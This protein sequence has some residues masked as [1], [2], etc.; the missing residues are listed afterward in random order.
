LTYQELTLHEPRT[1][2]DR[3][4]NSLGMEHEIKASD[5]IEWLNLQPLTDRTEPQP[6][7]QLAELLKA[8]GDSAGSKRAIFE[9]RRRQ[10]GSS[11]LPLRWWKVLLA[12]LEQQPL[13]I[14]FPVLFFTLLGSCVFKYAECKG[15]I[16]PTS[17]EAYIA[18]SKGIPY[19][20]AYPRFNP[21][22]Y[23]L[24]NDLPLVKLGQDDKWAPD[25]SHQ[26]TDWI[27]SYTFLSGF[28]WLLILA[29]WV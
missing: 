15:A 7:M 22:I 3:K 11:W 26:P 14:L 16:A 28:R 6:W 9:M 10:V 12:R 20:V 29:G 2:D 18:W 23:S 21:I 4:Q 5:R 27:T 1:A 19:E 8:K 25:P 17:K 24:E 13:W